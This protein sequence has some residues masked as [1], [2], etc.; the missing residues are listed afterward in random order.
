[1]K[2]TRYEDIEVSRVAAQAFLS[3]M[4]KLD[5]AGKL[6]YCD[7]RASDLY[8]VAFGEMQALRHEVEKKLGIK[9]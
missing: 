3:G 7:L 4:D 6:R 9:Q 2:E 1:M 8:S 5:V